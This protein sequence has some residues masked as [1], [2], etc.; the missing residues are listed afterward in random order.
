MLKN[1]RF[2]LVKSAVFFVFL[3]LLNTIPNAITLNI[4]NDFKNY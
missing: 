2:G 1:S 3:Q 4:Q